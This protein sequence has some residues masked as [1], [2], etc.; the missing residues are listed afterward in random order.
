MDEHEQFD[1]RAFREEETLS[2]GFSG[3][4]SL[5]LLP[6]L[7]QIYTVAMANG[8]LDIRRGSESGT[9]WFERGAMV[10]A[11]CNDVVGKEAV[12]AL[13]HWK[14]GQFSFDGSRTTPLQSI[15]ASWEEV[16]LEGCRLLDESSSA[17]EPP[18]SASPSFSDVFTRLERSLSG[19]AGAAVL[20]GVTGQVV[21][22]SRRSPALDFAAAGAHVAE[23]SRQQFAISGSLCNAAST[24]DTL[25]IFSDQIHLARALPEGN[26]LYVVAAR[27]TSNLAVI[28][29]VV[30]QALGKQA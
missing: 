22:Q 20:D 29:R 9:I 11:V 5:P 1:D 21:A 15:T 28:R 13:L 2:P 4:I 3:A 14:D 6:D 30:D 16:L 25:S 24:L 17:Q 10:H 23:L 12:Y 19:F 27:S 26:L 7:I 8:A 18:P